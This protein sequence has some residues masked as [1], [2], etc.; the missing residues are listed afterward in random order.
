MN[1]KTLKTSIL[2]NTIPKFLVFFVEEPTLYRQYLH[3]ISSTLGKDYELY[4]TIKEAIY[5]IE[6]GIKED[7]I[8]VVFVDVSVG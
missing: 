1:I 7:H 4:S 5:D 2:S 3:S 8:Y 6:T